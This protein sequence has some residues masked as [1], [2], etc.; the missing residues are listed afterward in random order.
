VYGDHNVVV[1]NNFVQATAN[2][3]NS[4]LAASII[5]VQKLPVSLLFEHS[6]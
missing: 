6:V 1:S 2:T 3:N 5:A 4:V